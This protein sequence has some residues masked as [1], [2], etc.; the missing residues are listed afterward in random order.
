MRLISKIYKEVMQLNITKTTPIKKW[1]EA[2]N[3]N[4]CTDGQQTPEKMPNIT[5]YQGDAS[6]NYSKLPHHIYENGNY[7]KNKKQVL[8]TMWKRGNPC[9]W[10]HKLVENS[11]EFL[12]KL[13]IELPYNLS[14]SHMGIYPEKTK[15]VI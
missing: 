7:L 3:R 12:K 14:T 13:K 10:G 1:A 4:F 11:M 15:S 5:N 8:A 9:L 2:L 6:Q